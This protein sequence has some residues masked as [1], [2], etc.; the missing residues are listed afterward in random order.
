[1]DRWSTR[2]L[3]SL[4]V[5][6]LAT[7]AHAA[8]I[9]RWI[10]L[11]PN[12]TALLRAITDLRNDACPAASVD[13][14]PVA[15]AQR[16]SSANAANSFPITLCEAAVPVGGST[17]IIDGMTLKMPAAHPRRIV[18]IG[19]T[20][21]RVVLTEQQN[22]NDPGPNGFPLPQIAQMVATFSP[23]LIVHVGDYYYR[24]SPCHPGNAGCAG[25]PHGDT[26]PAWDADWFTPARPIM[27]AAPLAMSR[28]NHES[29]GR[30]ARGWYTL[31]D[32]HPYDV[33]AVSCTFG[34]AYDYPPSYIVDAGLVS[35]IMFDSSFANTGDKSA[36]VQSDVNA[37]EAVTAT[38]YAPDVAA[39]VAALNGKPAFFVTH[40]PAYGFYKSAQHGNRLSL[41]GATPDEL[42]LFAKG[43]P[44]PIRLLLSGHIH[45]FEAIDMVRE[46]DAPQLVVGM[47]GTLL[48]KQAAP[49][50]FTGPAAFD[51][52]AGFA[53]VVAQAMDV[54][55]EFG[56]AV[57]DEVDGGYTVDLYWLDGVPHGRCVLQVVGARR[58]T[59]TG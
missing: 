28:G 13:G 19:D 6:L 50:E 3:A 25:S 57:L 46:E 16:G 12:H 47:S 21:C 59:C 43:V 33:A 27:A 54:G 15:L 4:T 26:W 22:C 9:N 35:L 37:V 42:A 34:S 30:G 40:R 45:Q 11:A 1:M 39:Q 24:E 20:G 36:P 58:L 23:D 29:C 31:L 18:V 41:E 14:A 44:D 52:V 38:H 55:R 53:P 2:L 8:T 48:D 51:R 56:F 32:P 10:Q 5:I 17:A 49:H 7:P